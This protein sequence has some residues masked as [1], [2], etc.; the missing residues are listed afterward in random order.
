MT[1]RFIDRLSRMCID[2]S[3]KVPPAPDSTSVNQ[4]EFTIVSHDSNPKLNVSFPVDRY[5][6]SSSMYV[7]VRDKDGNMLQKHRAV[8]AIGM[9]SVKISL[10]PPSRSMEC[11]RNLDDT[12][13]S[14]LHNDFNFSRANLTVPK[15]T[16]WRL[17]MNINPSDGN[18][19]HY[20][21]ADFWESRDSLGG[22]SNSDR[23]GSDY[24]NLDVF[25]NSRVTGIVLSL[26]LF[27]LSFS[28]S[29]RFTH[30]R[31]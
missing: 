27:S 25:S 13:G 20:T 28:I 16:T 30:I 11:V 3:L 9:E 6:N 14:E 5:I 7:T 17:A 18:F 12:V 4:S 10:I 24:K 15:L 2:G 8:N 19:V 21:N 31:T 26:S 22:A 23:L 29:L 1:V